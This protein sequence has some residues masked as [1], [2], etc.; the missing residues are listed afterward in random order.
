MHAAEGR[1]EALLGE[2]I[3]RGLVVH[4]HLDAAG[5]RRADPLGE[6][7]HARARLARGVLVNPDEARK[8]AALEVGVAHAHAD[9]AGRDQHDVELRRRTDQ[10]EGD[11]VPGREVD[12]GAGAQVRRDVLARRRRA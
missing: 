4:R 6:R 12:Q 7:E 3:E 9:H 5:A 2:E 11:V 8:A 10:I 1:A